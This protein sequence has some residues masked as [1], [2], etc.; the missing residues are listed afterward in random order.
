MDTVQKKLHHLSLRQLQA[1]FL[2]AKTPKGIFTSLS[3]SKSLHAHGKSLGGIFSSLSR[4]KIGGQ[5]LIIPWGKAESG[6][7]LRWKLNENIIGKKELLA[8]TS[9]L[10][11]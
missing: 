5:N 10:L 7:G 11:Q 3:T 8:I 9:A 6:Q 1:L 4:Q 2:L